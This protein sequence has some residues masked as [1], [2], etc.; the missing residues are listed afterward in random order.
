MSDYIPSDHIAMEY[1]ANCIG[2]IMDADCIPSNGR[3]RERDVAHAVVLAANNGVQ[4]AH[5]YLIKLSGQAE[6]GHYK[7]PRKH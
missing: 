7:T 6:N 1:I 2:R 3:Q 4:A 5:D